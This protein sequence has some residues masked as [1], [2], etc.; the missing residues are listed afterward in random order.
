VRAQ[1]VEN[2][3]N[4]ERL[5]NISIDRIEELAK[6]DGAVPTVQLADDVTSLD[7]QRGEQRRSAVPFVVVGATLWMT[8]SH[9][10]ERLGAIE[11]LNL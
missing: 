8:R 9:R 3:V 4:V 7:I 6:L 1:V 11:R 5:R 2:E 10:E